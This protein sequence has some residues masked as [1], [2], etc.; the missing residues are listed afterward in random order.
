MKFIIFW[1]TYPEKLSQILDSLKSNEGFWEPPSGLEII[2]EYVTPDGK[3]IQVV[4][5]DGD[6]ALSNYIYRIGIVTG[7]CKEI[8][9]YPVLSLDE[10]IDKTDLEVNK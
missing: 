6:Y 2:S 1:Q 9:T 7:F 4:A 3:F 5:V 8:N 10:W